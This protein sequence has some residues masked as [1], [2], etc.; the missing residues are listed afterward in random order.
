[1]REQSVARKMDDADVVVDVP[2][3]VPTL[4]EDPDLA[5]LEAIKRKGLMNK[6]ATD[7][8]AILIGVVTILSFGF[9]IWATWR[10]FQL[11]AQHHRQNEA[12]VKASEEFRDA[13]KQQTDRI[14]SAIHTVEQHIEHFEYVFGAAPPPTAAA[15]ATAATS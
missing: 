3:V 4:P 9:A 5:A 7:L 10:T 15:G 2:A 8:F 6:V 12:F 1:M 14:D 13:V 11:D